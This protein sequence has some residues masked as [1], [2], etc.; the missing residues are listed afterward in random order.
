MWMRIGSHVRVS[1]RSD[2][3]KNGRQGKTH[4][5]TKPATRSIFATPSIGPHDVHAA[6]P[7]PTRVLSILIVD[8]DSTLREG[9]GSVLRLDGYSVAI[10]GRGDEALDIL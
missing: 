8:D 6:P 7:E 2:Q 1:A 3:P 4:V 10:A 5:A 9:C